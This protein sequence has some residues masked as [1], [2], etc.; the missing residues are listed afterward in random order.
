MAKETKT[1]KAAREER[2]AKLQDDI[3][4]ALHF[5]ESNA[6]KIKENLVKNKSDQLKGLY[7]GTLLAI[8]FLKQY[9]DIPIRRKEIREI[10]K[11]QTNYLKQDKICKEL[12]ID[13]FVYDF[14]FATV[15]K[16]IGLLLGENDIMKLKSL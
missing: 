8:K 12:K 16:A 6:P 15:S 2:E 5:Y 9:K 10:K 11:I 14:A 1:E 7:V 13:I 3:V 4:D